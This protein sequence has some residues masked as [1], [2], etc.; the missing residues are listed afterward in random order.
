V[1][2]SPGLEVGDDLFDD[3]ANP[4]DL[5]V[6]FFL[7]VQEIAVSGLLDGSDHLVAAVSFV[8]QPVA[9]IKCQENL[10]F[11]QAIRVVTPALDRRPMRGRR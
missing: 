11:T 7:P 8:A 10:G 3:V 2:D 5:S 4:V 6:E 9:G 1:Y